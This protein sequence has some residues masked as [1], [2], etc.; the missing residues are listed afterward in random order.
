M[1]NMFQHGK[2]IVKSLLNHLLSAHPP[3][4]T[5]AFSKEHTKIQNES[6][7]KRMFGFGVLGTKI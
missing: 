5:S 1:W 6:E 7:K 3:E 4:R 2:Q